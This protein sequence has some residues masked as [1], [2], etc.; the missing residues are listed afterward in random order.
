VQIRDRDPDNVPEN[1][2]RLSQTARALKYGPNP[3]MVSTE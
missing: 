3:L 1:M 2:S